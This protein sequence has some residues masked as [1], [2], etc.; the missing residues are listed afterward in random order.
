ML[1]G[2]PVEGVLDDLGN[3]LEM[4]AVDRRQGQLRRADEHLDLAQAG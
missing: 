3:H 4:L 2:Q 1:P